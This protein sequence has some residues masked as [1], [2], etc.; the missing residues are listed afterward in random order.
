MPRRGCPRRLTARA[1]A[2]R[3]THPAASADRL[4]RPARLGGKVGQTPRELGGLLDRRLARLAYPAPQPAERPRVVGR[5]LL[6]GDERQERER[7]VEIERPVA[8]ARH[9]LG[10]RKREVEF[11]A[12]DRVV[13]LARR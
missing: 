7:E 6:A 1:V 13:E 12:L 8:L 5:R 9:F 11:T 4:N 2:T 10:E 3:S